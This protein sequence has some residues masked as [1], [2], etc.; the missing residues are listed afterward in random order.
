MESP[1]KNSAADTEILLQFV[2]EPVDNQRLAHLCGALDENLRQIEIALEVSISR[3]GERFSIRGEQAELARK[4]LQDFYH[5][6]R[7]DLS[8]EHLQLGLIEAM[9]WRT[10]PQPPAD[11]MPLLMTR[12]AEV[13]GRTPRQ[14]NYLQA[15]QEHDITFGIGPA[16]TGK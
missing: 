1:E 3:R 8:L 15:I 5:D 7:H 16:G 9:K 13:R 2:L 6:A 14:N 4:V 11:S 10:V 12:K